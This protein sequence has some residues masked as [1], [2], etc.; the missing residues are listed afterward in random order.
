[1][2]AAQ[3]ALTLPATDLNALPDDG[4][5]FLFCPLHHLHL[6]L[7]G[8]LALAGLLCLHLALVTRSQ[9]LHLGAFSGLT[10]CG[11]HGIVHHLV[12][13]VVPV[14]ACGGG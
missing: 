13:A 4:L 12:V 10:P 2:P 3:T 14:G 8:Q 7:H 1:M 6:L 5:G 9:S 11:A